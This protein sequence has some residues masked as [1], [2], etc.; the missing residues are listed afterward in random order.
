MLQNFQLTVG[1]TS[2]SS[3]NRSYIDASHII[4]IWHR[5]TFR[6]KA[7]ADMG[8]VDFAV[9]MNK[10]GMIHVDRFSVMPASAV[11]GVFRKDF[12][13]LL[14]EMKP[15]S[16]HFFGGKGA[17]P[18]KQSV[19][20]R[21]SRVQAPNPAASEDFPHY[22]QTF[23]VGCLE[24][25]RLAEYLGAEPVP[26]LWASGDFESSVQDAF[27]LIEFA[28][29]GTDTMWGKLR[30]QLG[31]G[32]PFALHTVAIAG[33]EKEALKVRLSEKF[34]EIQLEEEAEMSAASGAWEEVLTKKGLPVPTFGRIGYLESKPLVLFNGEIAFGTARYHL[35]KL[36]SLLTGDRLLQAQ[37]EDQRILISCSERDIFTA[38]HV[39]NPTAEEPEVEIEGDFEFGSL[40]RIL[41]LSGEPTCENTEEEPYKIVPKDI[42]PTAP[43]TAV[44]PPFSY[45]V[46]IFRK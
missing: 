32:T 34:P 15:G 26:V 40:M 44:L 4:G 36:K 37:A 24:Y 11:F 46:L 1:I 17:Y 13:R 14:K 2:H 5:Y 27:D 29:G 9:L 16:V 30:A 45:T 42:A 25:F 10:E 43:R 41:C 23:G 6:L 20:E 3:K 35:E 28:L 31:H 33:Q 38:V 39:A 18:W 22:G 8:G 12:V 7:K 19:G 21:K